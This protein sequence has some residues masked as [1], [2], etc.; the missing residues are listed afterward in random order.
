[1]ATKIIGSFNAAWENYDRAGGPALIEEA[2]EAEKIGLDSRPNYRLKIG[3]VD[4]TRR[5]ISINVTFSASGE[6]GM[7]LVVANQLNKRGFHRART[8]LWIGYGTKLVPYFMGKLAEPLDH[9]SGLYSTATAFG[10]GTQMGQRHFGGRVSYAGWDLRL[11]WADVI[12][13]FGADP[14]RFNF[15]GEHAE[16]LAPDFSEFGLETSFLEAEQ[17]ILEPMGF[18]PMDQLG[19]MHIVRKPPRFDATERRTLKGVWSDA[20]YPKGGFEFSQ[21]TQNFYSKVIVFRRN[22]NFGD[23]GAATL[24]DGMTQDENG[25]PVPFSYYG[26]DAERLANA[27][28][29]AAKSGAS[30][31]AVYAEAEV[32]NTTRFN[33]H[34][35]RAF[36][37]P[38]YPGSQDGAQRHADFLAAG[39]SAGVGRY[40]FRCSPCD[41]ELNDFFGV[42]RVEETRTPE[43]QGGFA[44]MDWV[45]LGMLENVLYGCQVEEVSLD[46]APQ[47]FSMQITGPGVERERALLRAATPLERIVL[48]VPHPDADE[49]GNPPVPEPENPMVVWESWGD[50]G[51]TFE[52]LDVPGLTM[53]DFD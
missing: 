50:E 6:S 47:V 29:R 44:Q 18:K 10:L 38:D 40:T 37:V 8:S 25:D 45:S 9:P 26:S 7:R 5:V 42:E 16:V 23:G 17:S 14:D 22:E 11:A 15:E 12:A 35:G 20:D 49:E 28:W 21:P 53:E 2:K 24:G 30:E 33:V 13:R 39:Y 43:G 32:T 46:I 34:Q 31:Y 41:Y 51:I 3:G 48:S 36:I 52:D 27:A 1:M 4:M 19:G